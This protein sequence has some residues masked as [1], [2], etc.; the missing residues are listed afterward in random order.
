MTNSNITAQDVKNFELLLNEKMIPYRNVPTGTPKSV[1]ELQDLGERYFPNSPYR[2][3]QAESIYDWTTS[4]FVRFNLFT[5]FVYTGL[6]NLPLDVDRITALIWDCYY[7]PSYFATDADFMHMFGLPPVQSLQELR[8]M[9]TPAYANILRPLVISE[10]KV[11]TQAVLDLPPISTR[12]HP[13]LY[14][15]AMPMAVRKGTSTRDRFGAQMLEFSGNTMAAAPLEIP[16]EEARVELFYPGATFRPKT[17]WSF[18]DSVAGARIWQQG[19]IVR[20]K[21]PPGAAYWPA[22]A[23]ITPFSLNPGTTEFNFPLQMKYRVERNAWTTINNQK[24]LVLDVIMEG[25]DWSDLDW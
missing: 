17:C 2:L 19:I 8:E 9:M 15:G 25:L 5:Q 21:P 3:F 11:F 4:D 22:G 10:F 6:P 18:S 23:D 16:L 12:D 7:P 1:Q 24:V 13:M 20:A 14:R